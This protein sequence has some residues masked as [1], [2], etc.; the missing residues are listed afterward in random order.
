M[1]NYIKNIYFKSIAVVSVIVYHAK[2]EINGSQILSGGYLGV[3]L[4]FVIS[5]YIIAFIIN[6]EIEDKNYFSLFDFFDRRIRRIFP[7][8]L[9]SI[10][11]FQLPFFFTLISS[12]LI[13]YAESVNSIFL[14]NTN[15]HF[16]FINQQY[17]DDS[18]LEKPFLHMW[19]V[20]L[21]FQFYIFIYIIFF[22]FHRYFREKY[23]LIL[24][25]IFFILSLIY[26]EINYKIN[27]T[28]NFYLPFSRTW[29][30]LLGIILL[31]LKNNKF[32]KKKKNII[33]Y[34]QL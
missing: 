7:V 24:I 25:L 11:L 9:F 29:E 12:S 4:F 2:I 30:F 6:K 18:S 15:F 5:G 32:F 10:L 27:P 26:C 16:N 31:N 33:F 22:V 17:A 13:S 8:I 19:S 14:L 21:E 20:A 34:F 28:S 23:L 1:K 3:D